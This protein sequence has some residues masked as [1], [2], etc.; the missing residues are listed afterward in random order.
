MDGKKSPDGWHPGRAAIA[1]RL[2]IA[3][4]A[5]LESFDV[6]RERNRGVVRGRSDRHCPQQGAPVFF[7]GRPKCFEMDS[8]RHHAPNAC[9]VI[10]PVTRQI[11]FCDEKP[12]RP[13]SAAERA[14][15][16]SLATKN[17]RRPSAVC[18]LDARSASGSARTA[19]AGAA[20]KPPL[21]A[22]APHN[23]DAC[24]TSRPKAPKPSRPLGLTVTALRPASLTRDYPPSLNKR[25]V[26]QKRGQLIGQMTV[27]ESV[28][29]TV[30]ESVS[31]SH[32]APT[33]HQS[34]SRGLVLAEPIPFR[35]RHGRVFEFPGFEC[36]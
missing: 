12:P 10:D 34:V 13:R 14:W 27:Q 22:N 15:R 32:P 21:I 30:H 17:P 1:S 9:P 24:S 29:M 6:G 25:S 35:S 26:R 3:D 20:T 5:V 18:S 33:V 23:L 7:A 8:W 16:R 36:G 2:R 31:L 28:S 19:R 11:P 4:E